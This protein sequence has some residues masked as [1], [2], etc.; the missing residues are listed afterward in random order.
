MRKRTLEQA[1]L[2]DDSKPL[3]RQFTNDSFAGGNESS[4][5]NGE[6]VSPSIGHGRT[7][8]TDWTNH[9]NGTVGD[10]NPPEPSILLDPALQAADANSRLVRQTSCVG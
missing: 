1:G 9:E 7:W 10:M 4:I 3:Q 8:S 5:F 2:E 6:S